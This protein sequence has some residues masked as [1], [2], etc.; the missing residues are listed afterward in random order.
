MV[1]SPKYRYHVLKPQD[2]AKVCEGIL[3]VTAQRYDITIHELRVM[4]DHIHLF[5]EI[6]PRISPSKAF[7][8]LKGIS[9]RV[10][11]RRFKWLK[12]KYPQ[13][14]LWSKGKFLRSIGSVTMETIEHYIKR[15]EHNWNYYRDQDFRKDVN[16]TTL[17]AY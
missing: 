9:A 7:M 3:R 8:Y 12:E 11:F 10:L 13:G 1:W 5:V 4:A 15:S 2:I 6:P 17:I 16:Q 14:H